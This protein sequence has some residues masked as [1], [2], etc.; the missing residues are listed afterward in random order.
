VIQEILRMSAFVAAFVVLPAATMLSFSAVPCD[1]LDCAGTTLVQ[2]AAPKKD[3]P[4]AKTDIPREESDALEQRQDD[5]GADS[6]DYSPPS[7]TEPHGCI[8]R[9]APL[10]LLV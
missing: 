2:N 9:E 10:D 8:L 6:D 3:A 5:D 7:T 4:V 1:R